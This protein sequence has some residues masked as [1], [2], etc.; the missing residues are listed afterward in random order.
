MDKNLKPIG[1][2]PIYGWEQ[3]YTEP[4]ID[5]SKNGYIF[6]TDSSANRIEV[7][8][9]KGELLKIWQSSGLSP[10]QFNLPRGIAITDKYIYVVETGNHRVQ[11]FNLEDLL[12]QLK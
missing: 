11:R 4:F 9:K 6:I 1:Q 10:G 3:Y 7:F 8:N 5:I 12:K 2:I